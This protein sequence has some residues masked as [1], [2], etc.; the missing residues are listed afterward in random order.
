MSADKKRPLSPG[1]Q[2]VLD[3]IRD[4]IENDM[5][6]D[7]RRMTPEELEAYIEDERNEATAEEFAD[8]MR[9]VHETAQTR[10]N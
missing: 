3:Y 8:F 4:A 5:R 7:I 1:E 6:N 2:Q 9:L 10:S